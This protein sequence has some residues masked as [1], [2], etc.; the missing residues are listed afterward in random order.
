[1][2]ECH[3]RNVAE[4]NP[5]RLELLHEVVPAA[6]VFGLLVN[7]TNPANARTSTKLAKAAADVLGLQLQILDASTVRDFDAAFAALDCRW[8]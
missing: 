6:T 1:V 8:F 3:R 7:P 2:R 4:V 5:K